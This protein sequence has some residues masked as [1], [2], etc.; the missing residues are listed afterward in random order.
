MWREN[1]MNLTISGPAGTTKGFAIPRRHLRFWLAAEADV[2]ALHSGRHLLA[3]VSELSPRGCYVDTPDGFGVGTKVR[4]CIRHVGS[5]CE[6]T[7]RVIYVHK[8]WGMGVLFDDGPATQFAG[9]DK[10]LAELARAQGAHP[11]SHSQSL[12]GLVH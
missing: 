7:G 12:A 11:Q 10:W 4:L 9:L 5:N 1:V 3:T 6:L 2:T 8:G